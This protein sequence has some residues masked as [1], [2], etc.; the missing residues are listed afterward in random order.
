MKVYIRSAWLRTIFKNY[1]NRWGFILGIKACSKP[2]RI[3]IWLLYKQFYFRIA[4]FLKTVFKTFLCKRVTTVK[5]SNF[6]PSR[7]LYI[8]VSLEKVTM[9]HIMLP[10]EENTS[11]KCDVVLGCINLVIITR[12]W[13]LA[14]VKKTSC[15]K[16]RWTYIIEFISIH[17]RRTVWKWKD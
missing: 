11:F 17:N 3:K 8:H 2:A 10:S 7:L 4:R 13:K 5:G 6:V 9:C 15:L 12:R 1:E 14:K 16:A